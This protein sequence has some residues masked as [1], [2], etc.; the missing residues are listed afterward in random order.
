LIWQAGQA[1]SEHQGSPGL[2]LH[3]CGAKSNFSFLTCVLGLELRLSSFPGY[4][5]SPVPSW[6]FSLNGLGSHDDD[7][8]L[9]AQLLKFVFSSALMQNEG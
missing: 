9:V 7:S 1:G 6:E 2:G 3:V 5:I 4:A 8:F